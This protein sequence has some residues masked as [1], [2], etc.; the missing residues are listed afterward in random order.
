MMKRMTVVGGLAALLLVGGAR[1]ADARVGVSIGIGIPG[2]VFGAPLYAAPGYYP[3]APAYYGYPGYA[4]DAPVYYGPAYYGPP[5][6][7]VYFGG[8]FGHGGYPRFR[9]GRWGYRRG[10]SGRRGWR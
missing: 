5:V 8:R 10:W 9:D 2:I 7:G 6:G 4:Y 1:I 3:P